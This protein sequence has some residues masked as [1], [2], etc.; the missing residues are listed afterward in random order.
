MAEEFKGSLG[1]DWGLGGGGQLTLF[2][3]SKAH[4]EGS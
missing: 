2:E 1:N 3:A 4:K